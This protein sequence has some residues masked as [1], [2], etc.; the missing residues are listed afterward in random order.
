MGRHGT[1]NSVAFRQPSFPLQRCGRTD[2]VYQVC[3]CV[4]IVDASIYWYRMKPIVLN[5]SASTAGLHLI[6]RSCC[7]RH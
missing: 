6:I 4:L 2:D 7:S 1:R 5:Q 3:F